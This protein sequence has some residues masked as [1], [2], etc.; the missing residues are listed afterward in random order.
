M[1][2][3]LEGDIFDA[4]M[5]QIVAHQVNCQGRMGRGIAKDIKNKYPSVYE[6][7]VKI[8][9]SAS[10]RELIGKILICKDEDRLIANLFAQKYYGIDRR[11]TDY[12]AV[13]SCLEKLSDYALDNKLD[14]AIPYGM[15][16]NNAGGNWNIIYTMIQ[17]ICV[18]VDVYI[19]KKES[20]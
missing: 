16:C 5:D 9:D 10:I 8:C 3:F 13:A 2:I 6:N 20:K 14:I 11:H 7:Y 12:E 4:P 1:I 18:D 15:G 17:E 19:Y